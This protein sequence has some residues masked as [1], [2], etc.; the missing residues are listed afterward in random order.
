[1][2]V[3]FQLPDG[4][5]VDCHDDVILIGADAHCH[6]AVDGCPRPCHA[7]VSRVAGRWFI[8]S[9]GDWLLQVADQPP[10]RKSWLLA[11]QPIRLS[12]TGPELIFQP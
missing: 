12:E 11:G 3:T 7:R 5:R 1:M 6:V 8:E 2:S 9:L 10:A 4:R